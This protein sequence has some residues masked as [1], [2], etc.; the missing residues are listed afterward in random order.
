MVYRCIRP[1][2][3]FIYITYNTESNILLFFPMLD[4]GYLRALT[5]Y[6]YIQ[7]T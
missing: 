4:I 2:S 5:E 6:I 3:V 1:V 7:Y